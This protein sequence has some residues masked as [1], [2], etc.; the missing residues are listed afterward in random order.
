MRKVSS[1]SARSGWAANTRAPPRANRRPAASVT[2]ATSWST[3]RAPP[4]SAVKATRSPASEPCSGAANVQPGSPSASGTRGSGPLMHREQQGEVGDVA[5][6]RAAHRGGLPLVG[7]GPRRH[8]AERGSQ[9]HDAAERRGVAQ[10]AAHVGAVRERHHARRQ[11]AGRSSARAAGGPVGV[12][13][14]AGGAEDGVEGVRPGRELR[15]VGLAE[16]HHAGRADP[17]DDQVVVVGHVVREHR[18]AEGRRPP[19][20]GVGVLHRE[21]QAVQ[22]AQRAAAGLV[23]VGG[24][25]AVAGPVLVERDDRVELG[26]AGGDPVEVQVQQL[27]RR[28]LAPG[29]GARHRA[30]GGVDGQVGQRRRPKIE[31]AT[32]PSSTR[33]APTAMPLR[34]SSCE[35]TP[36]ARA[37]AVNTWPGATGS[38]AAPGGGGDRRRGP[39]RRAS[40]RRCRRTPRPSGATPRRASAGP[41][42]RP[43][44]P[45]RRPPRRRSSSHR[46]PRRRPPA[47]SRRWSRG[48][49]PPGAASSATRAA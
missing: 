19:G 9:A 45:R 38:A 26:V 20:G 42:R 44:R 5:G 15:H 17:L 4:R 1:A 30:R 24:A 14:V 39:R 43:C 33:P 3:S 21:G 27:A 35:P 8:P 13:R 10:R 6:Q 18:R 46:R 22:R 23:L 2:P 37:G 49:P 47:R 12:V 34:K 28:D 7:R 16:E 32:T 25:G 41:R 31:P 29:H 36:P 11:R 48:H 40:R